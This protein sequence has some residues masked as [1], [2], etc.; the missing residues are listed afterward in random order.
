METSD[1]LHVVH[2][3]VSFFGKF[4]AVLTAKKCPVFTEPQCPLKSAF[5]PPFHFL[6]LQP[7]PC[8]IWGSHGGDY[9]D[10]CL[11][12]CRRSPWWWRLQV[13]LK[14]RK[15][16]TGATTQK[17][18]IFNL[19]LVLCILDALGLTLGSEASYGDRFHH[20]AQENATRHDHFLPH[21]SLHVSHSH[22]HIRQCA[23]WFNIA[24]HNVYDMLY[25]HN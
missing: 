25:D 21:N 10:G 23:D 6:S 18:A 8:D 3:S 20:A 16:S 13:P 5:E 9:E 15:T 19:F 7:I 12:G 22:P 1:K 24:C 17:T 2:N 4:V 11:L 14:R